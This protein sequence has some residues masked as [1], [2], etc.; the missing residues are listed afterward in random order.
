VVTVNHDADAGNRFDHG[1]R[2]MARH[3]IGDDWLGPAGDAARELCHD[4]SVH[5]G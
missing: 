1:R 3:R 5:G 4:G 2:H